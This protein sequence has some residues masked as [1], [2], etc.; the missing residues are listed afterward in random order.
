MEG[1]QEVKTYLLKMNNN[2][3]IL[4]MKIK[5]NEKIEFQLRPVNNFSNM[6]YSKEFNFEELIKQLLL[7]NDSYNN[8]TKIFKYYDS[9]LL[10][11]N[12]SLIPSEKSIK[13]F[14]KKLIDSKEEE[15]NLALDEIKL[16]ID[17]MLKMLYD[18]IME[19]KLKSINEEKIK[20]KQNEEMKKIINKLAE[21]NNILKKEKDEMKEEINK[22]SEENKKLKT[23]LDIL[24]ERFKDFKY[25]RKKPAKPENLRFIDYL[26]NNNIKSGL[27]TVF[28]GLTDNMEYLIYN[29]K[30]N[31]NL[32]I[33][34]LKDKKIIR[35]LKG[36]NKKVNVIRYFTKEDKEEYLLSCDESKI[37]IIWD[38]QND[39]NKKYTI[40][41][42]YIGTIF[43][44]ILMF[45]LLHK[46]CIVLSSGNTN[47][48][49]KIYELKDE[50]KVH[51]IKNVYGTNK[52]NTNYLIPWDY[53][54]KH[55]IIELCD[56]KI[57]I[58]NLLDDEIYANLAMDPEGFHF[59]GYLYN[60]NYLCVSDGRNNFIRIWDLINKN[61]YK[62]INFDASNAY[63]ITK[64]NDNF[65]IVGCKSCFILVDI[66]EGK[67]KKKIMLDNIN[68]YLRGVKKIKM[69][70]LGECLI[71]SDDSNNI[72][73][74][75]I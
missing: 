13:L 62:Q 70:Q 71:G 1:D 24:H 60:D 23:T 48:Y 59:S 31:F 26:T 4:T 41:E 34:T 56:K 44:V 65:S 40:K 49:T 53:K 38:I 12:I 3:Y 9:E 61:V 5:Q 6:Y 69:I 21:E 16:S 36:H 46:D 28:T 42:K 37:S 74:F 35:A 18:D 14:Q 73:L 25:N 33:M 50:G 10:K 68:H 47:E 51:F 2:S 55:Y 72:R 52:N 22:I 20:I 63:E 27:F 19:A 75:S 39:Y 64:W 8:V 54:N 43:D 66:E 57:T 30:N 67:M 7:S 32:D 29:N 45:T 11:N 17:E 15:I 58:N